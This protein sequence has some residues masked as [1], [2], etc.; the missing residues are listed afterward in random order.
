MRSTVNQTLVARSKFRGP[1]SC[2]CA[3][4]LVLLVPERIARAHHIEGLSIDTLTRR[5]GVIAEGKV[6]AVRSAWNANQTQIHTTLTLEVERYHKGDLNKNT[7]DIRYLGGV[8]GNVTMA[9][10]GQPSF[11]VNEDVFIF[12][13]PNH[14]VRDVPF[15]GAHEGKFTVTTDP[16]TQIEGLRNEHME[17]TKASSVETIERIMQPV[18]AAANQRGEE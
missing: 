10:I 7:L 11:A 5:A 3:I 9:V 8:V 6:T 4:A 14:A 15:V 1:L 12:L 16:V 13:K 2:G 17:V 18:R